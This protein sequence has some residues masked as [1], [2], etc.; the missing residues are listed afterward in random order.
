MYCNNCGSEIADGAKFCSN[1][2]TPVTMQTRPA[3]EP[4]VLQKTPAE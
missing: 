1:C 2:G 4:E 3:P